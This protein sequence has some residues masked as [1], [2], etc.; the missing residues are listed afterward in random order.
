M[1]RLL[2][3]LVL[4]LGL[5]ATAVGTVTLDRDARAVLGDGAPAADALETAQGRSMVIAVLEADPDARTAASADLVAWLAAHPAVARVIG[6]PEAPERA[7]DWLWEHRFAL[8][9]P[10]ATHLERDAL[11]AEFARARAALTRL[12][13]S[14]VA[15]RYLLDPTGSYRRLIEHVTEA[16]QAGPVRDV[17]EHD[18]T[19]M[20][21]ALADRPF[22]AEAQRT[23]DAEIQARAAQH[24]AEVLILGPRSVTARI[25]ARIAERASWLT[26]ITV[27]AL[28]LWLVAVF[29][30]PAP[31]AVPVL[32]L[33]LALP[34][35]A[36]AVQAAFGSVHVIALGFGGALMGL[37]VDYPI[38]L[39]A[40]PGGAARRF[41]R[42]C[43][44]LGLM[45]TAAAFLVLLGVG[46][47]VIGQI[48]LFAATGLLAAGPA[49]FWL[50]SAL[51]PPLLRW[52]APRRV[53]ARKLPVCVVICLAAMGGLWLWPGA[54]VER[55]AEMPA[56]VRADLDRMH[57]IVD[58]P[59]GR[60]AIEVHGTSLSAVLTRQQSLQRGL[61]SVPDTFG[62]TSMLVDML[63]PRPAG[64]IPPP[65]AFRA[66][67]VG[68]LPE[69]GLR[70]DFLPQLEAAYTAARQST[71]VG[72][73]APGLAL[74][75]APIRVEAGKFIGDV[76]LWDVTVPHRLAAAVAE[77]NDPDI[78]FVDR[79]GDVA[80]GLQALSAMVR[81]AVITGM[82]VAA[83]LLVIA[84]RPMRQATEIIAA[85][86][87][88]C[89]A[90]AL[91]VSLMHGGLGIVETL[92][93][94]LLI[95]IGIDYGLLLGLGEGPEQFAMAAQ[96]VIL[97]AMTTL[98]A[99]LCMAASGIPI[100]ADMGLTISIGLVAMFAANAVRAPGSAA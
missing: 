48:G 89:A 85:T 4:A 6:M 33:A 88:A 77:L 95:G 8:S 27:A 44:L 19:V 68:A 83:L 100:L 9:P 99:F 98:I 56:E 14:T 87:A 82:L 90:T 7:L 79:Q 31:L 45:T 70:S 28:T 62:R 67:V 15:G 30:H 32:T 29:R 38:H 43:I 97:C 50:A 22:D 12:R 75:G 13:D 72:V 60:Y 3:C 78:R 51:R 96:S 21:A 61:A 49:S 20:F 55:L 94:L 63:P 76:R 36:L 16:A 59:S 39:A 10:S 1:T 52:T 74:A 37:A 92:A 73:E 40:H 26:G 81:Q 64:D 24:G 91:A 46:V 41:A 47:P 18:A 34:A 54:P 69:A 84:V 42:R 58:L 53:F 2:V 93:L 35:A 71:D 66:A 25:S 65:E 17:P 86:A 80:A 57:R 11:L 5:G 23:F